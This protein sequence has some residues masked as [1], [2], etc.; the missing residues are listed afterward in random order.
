[1]SEFKKFCNSL[2]CPLCG[3]QLDGNLNEMQSSLYCAQNDEYAAIYVPRVSA[4]VVES[5]IFSYSQYEYKI[6]IELST[7]EDIHYDITITR[8]NMDVHPSKRSQTAKI[9]I[10]F[11]SKY[12]TFFHK[13][14]DEDVFLKKLKTI[15]TFS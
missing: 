8:F 4:P 13:R 9:I 1:M 2:R 14:M 12:N 6:Y 10:E 7:E 3:S 11:K 5:I 15:I